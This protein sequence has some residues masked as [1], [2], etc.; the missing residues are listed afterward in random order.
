MLE[1][2]LTDLRLFVYYDNTT[3][4][5]PIKNNKSAK[6]NLL[7]VFLAPPIVNTATVIPACINKIDNVNKSIYYKF[8]K[9]RERLK[10]SNY[11]WYST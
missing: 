8:K 7:L 5:I 6:I 11:L 4:I 10:L 2:V 9:H 3:P 1:I